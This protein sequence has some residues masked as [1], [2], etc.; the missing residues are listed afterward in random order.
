MGKEFV[1]IMAITIALPSSIL[2][3]FF[4]LRYLNIQGYIPDWAIPLGIIFIVINT[5][6]L[7]WMYVKRKKNP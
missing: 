2:G 5:F 6:F 4:I 3:I 1:K 7:I